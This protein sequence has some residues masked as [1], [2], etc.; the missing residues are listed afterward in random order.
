LAIAI[1]ILF[2]GTLSYLLWHQ[3]KLK[4]IDS[5]QMCLDA[6]Y[7]VAESYPRQCHTPDG[8]GFT[9]DLPDDRTICPMDARQCPDGS[10]VGR[11]APDC[12]FADCPETSL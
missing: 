2:L 1:L 10:Y 11:Q 9:E 7:P 8:R 5:F 3:N 4:Q 6:G 12:R